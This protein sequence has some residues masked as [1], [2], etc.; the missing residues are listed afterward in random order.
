MFY[1]FHILAA[2]V[3]QPPPQAPLSLNCSTQQLSESEQLSVSCSS[4][5]DLATLMFVCT[6]NGMPITEGC[7]LFLSRCKRVSSVNS[8]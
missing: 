1:I 2:P 5:R 6:L 7:E 8:T 3:T 4:S